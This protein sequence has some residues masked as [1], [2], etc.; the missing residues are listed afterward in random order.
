MSVS[1]AE[2]AA[3]K[4]SSNGMWQGDDPLHFAFPLLILQTLLI[5][6]L[7]RVLALLLRPLRQPKVIAEIVAGILL[8]PSALGR[9]KAYLRALFPPWS[10]PVLESVASLGLLFFLFLVGLELDLRSVRRS[11]RR[12]F[13]IA[14]AGI[15]LPFACGVGVAFVI[16]R[17]IPGADEAGYAPFLVFMGVAMSI[18]AFPVLA[19]I[20]AELKLLTTAIGETALAAA[21]FNDVAAWVLL[22]LAVAISGSGDDRRSPVTSLWVL[23]S[24]AAFVA[25][26]MLAV[27]PLMSWVARRSDSG[28]GGS[29][30]WVAFTLAGVLASGL[31]TDMIGIHAIFGAFVFGLT[32]PKDGGFAGRVTERVEDLVSELLLPLYFAS[33]GLKTDVATIRGGGALGILALIIVTACAG[34]IMGTFAVAMACGMGAKEAIVLGVLMNTKGLVELIVL[35]IG[36]ERK[37]LNEETF[38]I[39]VLMALVTTFIT[40][41]TVMAIYKPARA[42]GRRRLHPRKLHG[43]TSAPSSPSSAA[44]GAAGA[45]AMELRVLACI[46]GG[47]DVPALINLIETIRGHTQP[48][49]LVKLY[50]LRMVELTERTSSILMARAA[51]RNGLPFL[52]PYRRGDDQVDVAFGT[53]AQLGHVHVRPMTAVSALHTMHDDV[54]AVAEDKRVSLI[55]LPFHK[56][57][58]A[59]HGHG[60]GGGDEVENLG[61]EWRAVNRRILREAPCSV[62]VLVDR[63]FGGGEQVSSEQVA[64]GVCVLFFGGPDDRE[65][66]ELAGRMAEH[67][68]VQLTVV[69]FLDGKAGSE[70]HAEV[71]LRPTDARNAEKSYTFSTAVVN[72]HKE[73]ELD[74][75]AVA[76]FRQRMGDTVR[77]EERVVAG[78]VIEEVVAIG[79]SREYGLVVAGRGRLPSAMVAEL[80]VRPAEHPELG[81]IGDTLASA[82]HGVASS[83]LVVQQHDVNAHEV[84]VSVVQ[85][86]GQAHDGEHG[87]DDV[88]EP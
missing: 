21:A 11:G 40:T 7:S 50:I 63:S 24:G 52:R 18:T 9:N 53:Y 70:E 1:S 73:K 26:W 83:V 30:V 19:R 84:P 80:A 60:H 62:A 64:H 32:V 77:F 74:E 85:I 8:G 39:L 61:P 47:H 12:A 43:P 42:T 71:T 78:N 10:A 29:A 49:R 68:G 6:L 37:V 51:R 58:H 14:A 46:H 66:L 25:V 69:R 5:L 20:L 22:A 34:K 17:A 76:E 31:A 56:R 65:A 48:R 27:K 88:A 3:V 45:N 55:V 41:P 75:A 44:G 79:K 35:N 82:G 59:G 16:R 54:A 72:G 57:Q 28:G 86:D 67:P 13:A 15:S 87:K 36:R 4:T 81:P 38:A 2:M 23:L 33:S